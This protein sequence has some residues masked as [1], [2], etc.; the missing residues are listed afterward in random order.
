[1]QGLIGWEFLGV[2]PQ[3]S[4][5]K[6]STIRKTQ[7]KELF[8]TKGESARDKNE[9]LKALNIFYSTLSD[10]D[11]KIVKSLL[12]FNSSKIDKNLIQ[13]H[14]KKLKSLQRSQVNLA[15]STKQHYKKFCYQPFALPP[16]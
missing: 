8:R 11:R 14:E 9:K 2:F 7:L 13:N 3:S 10:P 16:L 1:M 15:T 4:E 5:P 12:D 6:S